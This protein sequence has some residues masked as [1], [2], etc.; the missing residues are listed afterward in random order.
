MKPHNQA[1]SNAA[2]RRQAET[3]ESYAA[4]LQAIRQDQPSS[5]RELAEQAHTAHST[6]EDFHSMPVPEVLTELVRYHCHRIAKYLYCAMDE[7]RWNTDGFAGW[8]TTTLYKL[9]DAQEHLHLLI[10]TISAYLRGEGVSPYSLRRYLQVNND[11]QVDAYVT[12][13]VKEHL[14]GLTG[15]D[16]PGE[17]VVW[18]S[19][20]RD[21]ARKTGWCD[22]DRHDILEAAMHALYGSYPYDDQG[23]DHLPAPLRSQAMAFIAA[24][25][26]THHPCHCTDC[27][28][29]QEAHPPV[30]AD[31]TPPTTPAEPG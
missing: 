28:D 17:A 26:P 3:G 11:R 21:I 24:F 16:R 22:P 6:A 9:T 7:G 20:G 19:V 14:A 5:A 1:R 27:M 4:A 10:G 30:M 13:T 23:L 31:H 12:P 25:E 29:D 2:R 18:Y 15:Q 8:Q